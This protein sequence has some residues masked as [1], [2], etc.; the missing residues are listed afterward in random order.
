MSEVPT[1]VHVRQ[2][3]CE[4][5]L[6]GMTSPSIVEVV[7]FEVKKGLHYALIGVSKSGK[8]T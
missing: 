8:L 4:L 1:F 3:E 2:E 6:F 5:A 7:H